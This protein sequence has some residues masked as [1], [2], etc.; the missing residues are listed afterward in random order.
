MVEVTREGGLTTEEQLR[1]YSKDLKDTTT[2]GLDDKRAARIWSAT[3]VC[4]VAA[5]GFLVLGYSV[6]Y[7]S[8]V[9][10]HLKHR[11]G[12]ASLRRTLDQDLFAVSGRVWSYKWFMVSM[13]VNS[14]LS[15]SMQ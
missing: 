2:R 3:Y 5:V 4:T 1:D 7:N 15:L 10:S 9:S 12:Y 8:P 13:L 11:K 6:G 14:G